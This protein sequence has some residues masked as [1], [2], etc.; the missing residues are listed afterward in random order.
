MIRASVAALRELLEAQ[1]LTVHEGG[2]PD[3]STVPYAV[4]WADSG[5]RTG[6]KLTT[7]SDRADLLTTVVSV[8]ST[9]EQAGWVAE[10]VFTALLDQTPTITGRGCA[11]ITHETSDPL[12]RDSDVVQPG[13]SVTYEQ[14]D[15]FRLTSW[16]TPA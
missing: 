5:I 10:R 12:R 16:P 7:G 15:V 1:N 11:P 3:G 14:V 6:T 9:E 13:G 4:L 8:G 2:A